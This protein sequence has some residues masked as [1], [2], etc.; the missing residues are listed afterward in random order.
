MRYI[1]TAL[2]YGFGL[3]FALLALSMVLNDSPR[4]AVLMLALTLLCLPFAGRL[5]RQWFGPRGCFLRA[6]AGLAA[7]AGLALT[8]FG[9]GR[10]S[11]YDSPEIRTRFH[12][13][14]AQKLADWPVPYE[15]IVLESRYGPVHVVASGSEDAPPLLLLHASAV[16]GWSWTYNAE[17]LSR[18]YRIFA[19]DLIGDAGLSEY[20]DLSHRM[21]TGRDQADHYAEVATL[22]G[23]DRASVVGASEGGFIA[24]N[25]ALHYPER[26]EKLA[27]L[28]PMG[29]SGAV[30]A[31]VRI[32]LAQLF[33][34]RP[35]QEATFRWAFSDSEKLRA[36]FAEWFPLVM[37]GTF[38]AKVAPWP[39]T[40]EERQ[41][42]AVPV[43]YVFGTRDNVVGNAE[44]ARA[45]VA[46]VPGA[47]IEVIEAGHL[48]AAEK[49]EVVNALLIAFFAE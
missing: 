10:D 5:F 9:S 35:V 3:I 32:T 30:R 31:A 21:L 29:Y 49:P 47:R 18:H 34:L 22:L 45:S 23:I 41:A 11:I 48:M 8:L 6:G 16:S 26:V 36:D 43:L 4:P 25:Y 13:L 12:E 28:G 14:Y 33:P 24:T 7:L 44:A 19:I 20:S 40:A 37:S 15:E 1:L 42:I 17:A 46:D 27:L 39:F 2:G 38:P